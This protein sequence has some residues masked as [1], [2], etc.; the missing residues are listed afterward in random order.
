LSLARQGY[1]EVVLTGVH[2]GAYGYDA[3]GASTRGWPEKGNLTTL[4]TDLLEALPPTIRLRLSS[5]EPCGAMQDRGL[6]P[7]FLAL[8]QD[9]RLCRHLHLPLQ[10]ASDSVLRRMGRRYHTDQYAAWLEL[11]RAAIPGLAITTDLIAG[12]PGETIADHEASMA[13]VK[14][15]RFARL[16]VFPYS[17]RPGTP[18]AHMADQVPVP[19]RQ[20]RAAQLRMVG[21]CSAE[22]FQQQF[23]GQTLQVLW[24]TRQA[25]GRWTG[26]T[27]NYIRVSV[28]ADQ[29]LAN[30][31]SPVYLCEL[32]RSGVRGRLAV[33]ST[34]DRQ[35]SGHG[36]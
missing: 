9:H 10:S 36:R 15:A 26:L 4:L 24:E 31:L 20:R 22:L 19:E 21:Q 27:D 3:Q 17:A 11:A 14:R 35:E 1:R 18:A 5:I 13:F 30:R 28:R 8:W 25:D 33:S 34:G 6:R 23:L 16:H 12:F 2:L 29:D 32:E 7:E